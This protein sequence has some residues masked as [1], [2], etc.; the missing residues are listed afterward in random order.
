MIH[1]V[2][3]SPHDLK[4][5][6]QEIIAELRH[7]AG[8]ELVELIHPYTVVESVNPE[9]YLFLADYVMRNT[10]LRIDG[11]ALWSTEALTVYAIQLHGTAREMRSYVQCYLVK[12]VVNA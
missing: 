12:E 10:Q 11:R 8:D 5:T 9:G 3:F 2:Q 4:F 1:T 7:F 6:P